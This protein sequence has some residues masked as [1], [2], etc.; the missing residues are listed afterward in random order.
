[1]CGLTQ[2]LLYAMAA[3][4]PFFGTVLVEPQRDSGAPQAP[5]GSLRSEVKADIPDVPDEV[6]FVGVQ[7]KRIACVQR[8]M[9]LPR[10]SLSRTS[11]SASTKLVRVEDARVNDVVARGRA[12]EH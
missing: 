3:K 1:M 12:R 11:S 10:G 5:L 9:A 7:L 4:F 2:Q 8:A 6:E